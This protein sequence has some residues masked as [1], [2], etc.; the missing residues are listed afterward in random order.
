MIRIEVPTPFVQVGDVYQ[1]EAENA[2]NFLIKNDQGEY[3]YLPKQN[4]EKI[5]EYL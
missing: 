2:L 1:V 5:M 4:C 3:H